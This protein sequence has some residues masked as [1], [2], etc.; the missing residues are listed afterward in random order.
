[1]V[2]LADEAVESHTK[3]SGVVRKTCAGLR[4]RRYQVMRSGFGDAVCDHS[5]RWAKSSTNK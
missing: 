1:M 3:N 5:G 2:V 4:Q